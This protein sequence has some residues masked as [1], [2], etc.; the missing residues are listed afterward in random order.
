MSAG[1]RENLS[2]STGWS[3]LGQSCLTAVPRS[4]RV[5]ASSVLVLALPDKA[6]WPKF[7]L[8]HFRSSSASQANAN[9]LWRN[10]QVLRSTLSR[11]TCWIS[12]RGPSVPLRVYLTG[13]TASALPPVSVA[14]ARGSWQACD[15]CLSPMGRTTWCQL[16]G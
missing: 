6:G 16:V 14:L 10:E 5:P 3:A 13:N 9:P 2:M 15:A 7:P 12:D 11:M 8:C 1:S 4:A